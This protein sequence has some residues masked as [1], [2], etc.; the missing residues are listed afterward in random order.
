[1]NSQC[2]EFV[3]FSKFFDFQPHSLVNFVGGGG[4][5][6]LIHRL[7]DECVEKGHVLYTTTTRIHPP[8]L[9]AKMVVISTRNLPVLKTLVTQAADRCDNRNYKIV[10]TREFMEPDLLN[11]V[12]PDFLESVDPSLC[13]VFLN[14]ADGSAR[15]SLK[16][17][18]DGEPVLMG[19]GAYLVPVV[20]ID[21]LHQPA[22]P[23]TI[24]RFSSLSS[25]F[26]IREGETITPEL[27]AEILMHPQGVCRDWKEGMTV[28]P[29]INKVDTPEQE[30]DARTLA[31]HIIRNGTFPVSHVVWGSA[32]H[33]R[34]GS[35][36]GD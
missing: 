7:M 30:A 34:S 8:E 31:S 14:E 3:P 29:F 23:G 15:F 20:G 28:I 22:G 35:F 9:D 21:C 33:R 27:A 12:P 2:E 19:G 18:R 17:P 26:S 10:A 25:K 36:S 16:L 6:I 11:G 1:V 4:K 5:T 13:A 32:R 24:F